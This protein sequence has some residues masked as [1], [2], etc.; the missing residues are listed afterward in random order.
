MHNK[1]VLKN[2]NVNT[3]KYIKITSFLLPAFIPISILWIYPAFYTI[4]LSLTNWDYVSPTYKFM[5]IKNFLYLFSNPTFLRSIQVTFVFLFSTIFITI[6]LSLILAL[7]IYGNKYLKGLLKFLFFSP[8]VTPLVAV[9]LVWIFIFDYRAGLVNYLF[10]FI[11]IGKINWIGNS[12]YAL[13]PVIVVTIWAN[14]GWNMIFFLGAL[15]KVPID[16]YEAA[17]IDGVSLFIKTLRITIPLISPTTLFLFIL[18]TI[19]FLQAYTQIDILTQGGP[20]ESTQTI[21]YLFY[22]YAFNYFEVGR[23]SAIAVIIIFI[24]ALLSLT[25][26]HFSGKYIYYN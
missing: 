26:F 1:T 12:S 6:I 17:D 14:L 21:Q 11:N 8:W 4:Y 3:I 25:Q 19:N 7:A 22:K 10:S 18:N 9:S 5:G 20:A 15:S 23:A 2:R 24:T 16:L 13:I